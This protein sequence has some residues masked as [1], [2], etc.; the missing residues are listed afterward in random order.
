MLVGRIPAVL[1]IFVLAPG[2]DGWGMEP[3]SSDEWAAASANWARTIQA[4]RENNPKNGTCSS[5]IRS[6]L[7]ACLQYSKMWCWATGVAELAHFYRPTDF[8]E[9]GDD[10][11]GMECKIVGHK[12][13]PALPHECCSDGCPD[14]SQLCC[15]SMVGGAKCMDK[16]GGFSKQINASYCAKL[17]KQGCALVGGSLQDV[18]DAIQWTS[19]QR[20]AVSQDGPLSQQQLDALLSKGHPVIIAVYWKGGSG[21]ALTLGGCAASGEYYLHDPLNHQGSYQTLSYE[22]VAS[23]IPPESKSLTGKWMRTFYLEGD[24]PN[25]TSTSLAESQ[26]MV[27]P[28]A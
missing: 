9:A 1:A 4:H 21:H 6:S 25:G 19:G 7:P 10:C 24:L 23:Y 17:D 11:H 3:M 18:I 28:M 26:Q 13:N 22:Q 5:D 8:P 14:P 15:R 27:H 16:C 12:K 20:Y 2:I